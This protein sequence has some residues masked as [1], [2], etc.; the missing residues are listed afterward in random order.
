MGVQGRRPRGAAVRR[1]LGTSW[2]AIAVASAL[3]ACSQRASNSSASAEQA[4][5]PAAAVDDTSRA[6]RALKGLRPQ[7]EATGRAPVRWT[8]AER[9]AFYNVPGVSIAIIDKGRVAWASGIGVKEAGKPEPVTAATLF[10]AAS[11]SKPVTATGMLRLVEQG[12]LQLDTNVNRYLTSWKVPDNKFTTKEKVTLRRIVSHNAGLTVH[13]FPGY[14]TTDKIPTVIQVLN[15]EKPANTA[16]V[17]VDTFPG[18]IGRYSGGGTT[19]MQQLLVDVTGTPFPSLMKQLVLDP[20]GMRRSTFEQPLPSTRANEAAHAHD[21]KGVAIPGGWHI[22]PEMAPAG[23]WTTPTDLATW[24]LAIEDA[25]AG[26]SNNLL[27]REMATQML[28]E[29]KDHFG[30]GPQIGGAGRTFFFGHGGANEGFHSS[31]KYYPELGVGAA[32]MTNGDGGPGL[33]RE[34]ERALA[35]E[36]GWPGYEPKR[37]NAMNLDPAIAAKLAG[38]Y[39]LEGIDLTADVTWEAN[40]K[41]LMLRAPQLSAEELY[42]ESDTSFVASNLGWRVVFS[43]D[44]KTMSLMPDGRPSITATRV[45]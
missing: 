32:I 30:L 8:L 33:I 16:A 20:A 28:T 23:L 26:R 9:M 25:H 12:K 21:S 45:K 27:S 17:R 40:A 44:A 38:S 5:T 43:R 6:A 36:F 14:S 41:R 39:K 7:V 29:Q 15:G 34:V 35:D 19:I 13:G 37:V 22:Y 11:I 10:Q 3:T 4:G 42:A 24:A 31:L 18:A 1:S 2:R